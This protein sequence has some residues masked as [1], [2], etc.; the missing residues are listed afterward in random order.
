MKDQYKNGQIKQQIDRGIQTYYFEDGT[1][2]ATGPFDGQMQG[3]W[4][5]F[6]KSGELWQVGNLKQ[7]IKNGPWIRYDRSGQIEK[8]TIFENGKEVK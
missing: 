2:K 8:E 6:R 3:E 7:D 4:K 5:F 1:I